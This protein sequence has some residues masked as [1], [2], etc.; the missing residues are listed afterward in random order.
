MGEKNYTKKT[1]NLLSGLFSDD[2]YSRFG[3][4][5]TIFHG[6][7]GKS[8]DQAWNFR[9]FSIF[10]QLPPGQKYIYTCPMIKNLGV[11]K[12]YESESFESPSIVP[13]VKFGVPPGTHPSGQF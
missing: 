7:L 5:S 11:L 1:L 12:S 2:A 13:W 4:F 3:H 10:L 9:K 6:F 8:G